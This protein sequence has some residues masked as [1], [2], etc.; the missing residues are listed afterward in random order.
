MFVNHH[1][2]RLT[3]FA[4]DLQTLLVGKKSADLG[5]IFNEQIGRGVVKNNPVGRRRLAFIAGFIRYQ[6]VNCRL[7]FIQ[8]KIADPKRAVSS[9]HHGVIFIVILKNGHRRAR[10]GKALKINLSAVGGFKRGFKLWWRRRQSV[11]VFEGGVDP[12]QVTHEDRQP[13][14]GRN[15]QKNYG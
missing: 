11:L 3:D 4:A 1:G 5:R 6:S 2:S 7:P 8:K 15:P 14:Q 13:N 9:S 10:F 12:T